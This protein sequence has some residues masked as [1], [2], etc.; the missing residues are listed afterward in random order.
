[1]IGEYVLVRARGAGVHMGTLVSVDV[2][3]R[4]VVLSGSRQLSRWKGA[5]TLREVSLHG[6]QPGSRISEAVGRHV[7]LDVIE[8]LFPTPEARKTL[9]VGQWAR[10]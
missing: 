8:V 1:M 10:T 2:M 9:E 5:N 6:V 3:S 7:V 4:S